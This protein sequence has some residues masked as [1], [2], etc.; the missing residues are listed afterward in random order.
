MALPPTVDLGPMLLPGA[1]AYSRRCFELAHLASNSIPHVTD[2]AY[3]ADPF[4]KLDIWLPKKTSFSPPVIVFFH[5]GA[6][7]NGYKEWIGAM[8]PS[9]TACPAILVAPNYR[10][11]P[12]VRLTSAI[13]DCI[14]ALAWVWRFISNYGGNQRKIILAG[15]SAG[16]HLAALLTLKPHQL[17]QAGIP[18]SCI[19]QCIPISGLFGFE[20]HM[21]LP[22]DSRLSWH[23]EMFAGAD[24][25]HEATAD[26]YLQD[27]EIPFHLI[28]GDKD[29]P[30]V[31]SD[32]SRFL[33]AAKNG[34]FA[35]RAT[36]LQETD[37][38]QAHLACLNDESIF[39]DTIRRLAAQACTD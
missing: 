24:E 23:S 7:R 37:H 13:E 3:G 22:G 2:I 38:F 17:A 15:H 9:V 6:W 11:L 25:M 1:E 29:L 26:N 27:N 20:P 5:G 21:M 33:S 31:V 4:Q 18:H 12:T 36:V 30:E 19:A 10:L 39:L 28:Y 35:M 16:G 32:Q 14:K 34:G 8:A